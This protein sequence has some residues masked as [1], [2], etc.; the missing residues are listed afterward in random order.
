[1][2]GIY[3]STSYDRYKK[4]YQLN[5]SRGSFAN[6]YLFY[7]NEPGE[8]RVERFPGENDYDTYP[9]YDDIGHFDMY[10]GHTQS[11]TG[12]VRDY[13]VETTHPF[14]TANWL[15]A[16]NGVINNYKEIISKYIPD[17][18]C[19]VDSSVIPVFMEYLLKNK[20]VKYNTELM[21]S[22]VKN[23]LNRISGTYAVF[24]Y[25]IPN[26]ILYIARCGS[27]LFF[28][29]NTLEF[30]STHTEDLEEVPE[31]VLYKISFNKFQQIDTL[32]NNSSFLI[33]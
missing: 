24:I 10:L 7:S 32:K 16:H 5:K 23:T 14:E 8:Y 19:D 27:T 29:K 6:G 11:P 21:D 3:G 28:N 12:S 13:S 26:K 9:Q 1:M 4:L 30:S 22:I 18:K 20:P 17:H 15:V 33:F 2:C 31:C 25:N